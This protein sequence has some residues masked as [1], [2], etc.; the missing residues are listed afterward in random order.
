MADGR[1]LYSQAALWSGLSQQ[2]SVV[3]LHVPKTLEMIHKN[4]QELRLS[5]VG[6]SI[7]KGR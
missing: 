2:H 5:G 6:Q 4:F 1:R 3:V 7:K